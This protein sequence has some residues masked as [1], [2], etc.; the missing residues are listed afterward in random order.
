MCTFP[1][2]TEYGVRYVQMFISLRNCIYLSTY[3]LV[4]FP[5][6]LFS[7][8]PRQY[9]KAPTKKKTTHFLRPKV[10]LIFLPHIFDNITESRVCICLFVYSIKCIYICIIALETAALT[11]PYPA[12][13]MLT[14]TTICH[15]YF[16]IILLGEESNKIF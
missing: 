16:L 1:Q 10:K 9:F 12:C 14:H 15:K 2:F 7:R 8:C 6:C 5:Y 3:V 13:G 4:I 11:Q